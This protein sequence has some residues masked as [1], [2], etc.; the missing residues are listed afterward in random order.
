MYRKTI[1]G[2]AASPVATTTVAVLMAK[3]GLYKKRK[4]AWSTL[5]IGAAGTGAGSAAPTLGLEAPKHRS[6]PGLR[7]CERVLAR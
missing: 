1:L 2:R 7:G 4:N 3:H 5:L 6:T